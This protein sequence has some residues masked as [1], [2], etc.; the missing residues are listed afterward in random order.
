MEPDKRFGSLLIFIYHFC[1]RIAISGYLSGLSRPAH[2][3]PCMFLRYA[4]IT[5]IYK[6]K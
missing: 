1:D 2:G 5:M 6:T 3:S 4:R